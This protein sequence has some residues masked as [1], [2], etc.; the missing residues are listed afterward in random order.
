MKVIAIKAA[1]ATR[2]SKGEA[3]LFVIVMDSRANKSLIS[4]RRSLVRL[5]SRLRNYCSAGNLSMVR[6]Y[7]PLVSTGQESIKTCCATGV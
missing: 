5:N 3:L 1:P 6:K 2:A 7:P 4:V